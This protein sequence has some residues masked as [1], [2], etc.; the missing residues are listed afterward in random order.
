MRY[1]TEEHEL[2]RS[3]LREFLEKE[4]RPNI[5]P[6]RNKKKSLGIY[7]KKWVKWDI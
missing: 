1:F 7:G 4:V 2:F 6:G 5:N 3:S